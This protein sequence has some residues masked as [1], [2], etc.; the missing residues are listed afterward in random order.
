MRATPL[1]PNFYENKYGKAPSDYLSC[2]YVNDWNAMAIPLSCPLGARSCSD[3]QLAGPAW[4]HVHMGTDTLDW[5]LKCAP[6]CGEGGCG[7]LRRPE[8]RESGARGAGRGCTQGR[9]P[10]RELSWHP[11]CVRVAFCQQNLSPH[12]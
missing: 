4:G 10:A 2:C 12:M 11:L 3:G 7:K 9:Q 6:G 8:A 1:Q 5:F